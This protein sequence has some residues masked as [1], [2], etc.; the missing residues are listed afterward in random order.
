MQRHYRDLH[1]EPQRERERL[2]HSGIQSE[3]WP[4]THSETQREAE[5]ERERE[6]DLDPFPCL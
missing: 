2:R 3:T 1:T 6:T 5:A 4:Q